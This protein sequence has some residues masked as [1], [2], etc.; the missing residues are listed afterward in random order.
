MVWGFFQHGWRDNAGWKGNRGGN[1]G[2]VGIDWVDCWVDLT[3]VSKMQGSL[4]A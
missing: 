3:F 1:L 4:L 2:T